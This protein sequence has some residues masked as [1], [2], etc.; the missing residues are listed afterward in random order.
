[1]QLMSILSYNAARH[2]ADTGLE[3]MQDRDPQVGATGDL[4]ERAA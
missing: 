4:V 1:M 3:A 2:L